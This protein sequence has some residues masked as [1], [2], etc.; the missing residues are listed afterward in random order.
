MES[1]L[2]P[3]L[4]AQF[5]QGSCK[6]EQAAAVEAHID[7]CG[8]CRQVLSNL[9][10]SQRDQSLS[11]TDVI[12]PAQC[13]VAVGDVV[14][15]KYRVEKVVG[16]GGMGSVVAAWHE[17]LN[18]RVAL[19]FMLP[20]FASDA[21]AAARFSREA[22]SA[23]R[24]RSPHVCRV[25]DLDK[26]V[27]GTPFLVMEYLEGETL[28]RCIER[29]RVI[30]PAR[31]VDWVLQALEALAEAHGVGIIHRDL[32]PANLFVT[33]WQGQQTI[34]VLDFGIAKSVDPDIE[35]GLKSTSQNMMIG[36]PP[37]MAPEQLQPGK[38]VDARA[39]VWSM[40]VVLYQALTG[41]LPFKSDNLV[42]MM[43]AIKNQPHPPLLEKVPSLPVAV[44]QVVDGCLAKL[45]ENR[46]QTV[47]ALTQALK[48]VQLNPAVR[49]PAQGVR[50]RAAKASPA[51]RPSRVSW[52]A[53]VVAA[54]AGVAL[55][56]AWAHSAKKMPVPEAAA[57][58]APSSKNERHAPVTVFAPLPEVHT[59]V[60]AQVLPPAAPAKPS[61]RNVNPRADPVFGERR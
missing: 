22:R 6:S 1:H 50:P 20:Q 2:T 47:D 19:K 9:V 8:E 43:F 17:Q 14:A 24:L 13:P 41:E 53:L 30:A 57:G 56:V 23:A 35:Y 5:L 37:F 54:L 34:K 39:D 15:G 49:L 26:L 21:E 16:T 58:V 7:G 4:F 12:S 3:D 42:D 38:K 40:G 31:A 61:P 59:V 27:N 25:L 28:E 46:F 52:V 36:S 55:T 48:A 11:S 32:K 45:P 51:A 33:Q 18:H 60:P 29:D 10:R 44:A